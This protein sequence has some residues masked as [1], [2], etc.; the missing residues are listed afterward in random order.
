MPEFIADTD[1]T[2]C[3]LQW[4]DLADFTQGYLE[5]MLFTETSCIPMT[6][7]HDEESQEQVREGQAD[8]CIPADAG[9]GDIFPASFEKAQTDCMAFEHK[10]HDLL[11]EAYQG[12]YSRSQAGRDFWFTRNGHGVGFWDRKELEP[13]GA[14]EAL[15]S[16]RVD[17]PNWSK[18]RDICDNSLGNRLT[19]IAKEFG[20]VYVSFS[21]A[22][23]DASPTGYGFVYME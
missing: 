19:A 9:F 16:P 8:G 15:G 20:E 4:E 18:W 6:E 13:R 7:W 10:A 3:H 1:G 12:G 2:V 22:E 17:E 23:D 21:E 14:W 5:A 11:M